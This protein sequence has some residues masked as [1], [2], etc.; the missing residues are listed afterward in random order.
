MEENSDL[1]CMSVFNNTETCKMITSYYWQSE[2]ST[3]AP[4]A[5]KDDFIEVRSG[6]WSGWKF[7]AEFCVPGTYN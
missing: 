6:T 2:L 7:C 4:D 5:V 1:N 3:L